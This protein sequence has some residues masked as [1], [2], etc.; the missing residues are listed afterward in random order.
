MVSYVNP[1]EL[2]HVASAKLQR[3]GFLKI[4][5]LF[6]PAAVEGF[7]GLLA[8]Q[9][10]GAI[11]RTSNTLVNHAGGGQFAGYSNNVDLTGD[12][13]RGVRE[14]A[15]LHRLCAGIDEGRWLLTQGL[16]FEIKPGQK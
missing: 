9:L 3:D 14:S 2:S 6:T 5:G 13:V 8:A 15:A 10:G 7:R 12:V 1:I 11:D 16:G 4:G